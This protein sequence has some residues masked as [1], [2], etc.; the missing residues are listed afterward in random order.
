MTVTFLTLDHVGKHK[1]LLFDNCRNY[2]YTVRYIDHF[3]QLP[4]IPM[5]TMEHILKHL[6]RCK[7]VLF[8]TNDIIVDIDKTNNAS[9]N[10]K[11]KLKLNVKIMG[12]KYTYLFIF[13]AIVKKMDKNKIL[14]HKY[15]VLLDEYDF[16]LQ[17]CDDILIKHGDKCNKCIR[18]MERS[19]SI[20]EKSINIL[21]KYI[22]ILEDN[23]N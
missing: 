9:E 12:K 3:V 6:K 22:S 16:L 21:E 7:N 23:T 4:S 20:L 8:Y 13:D 2:R 5:F 15:D 18:I 11:V 10:I 19:V 17:L 14:L 1:L